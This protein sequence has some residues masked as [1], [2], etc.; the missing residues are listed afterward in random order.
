MKFEPNLASGFNISVK[1]MLSDSADRQQATMDQVT[2]STVL[3]VLKLSR[4]PTKLQGH[5]SVGTGEEDC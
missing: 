2:F 3:I 4:L 1:E 5:H